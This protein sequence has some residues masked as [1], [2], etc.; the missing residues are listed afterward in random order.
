MRRCVARRIAAP[1]VQ[2]RGA[3]PPRR[4]LRAAQHR[5]RPRPHAPRC[6]RERWSLLRDPPRAHR[7]PRALS[8]NAGSARSSPRRRRAPASGAA[9][10]TQS[11]PHRR[12]PLR[13]RRRRQR[14]RASPL[15]PR[16]RRHATVAAAR[17]LRRAQ[18]PPCRRRRQRRRAQPPRSTRA[19]PRPT[20]G[21]GDRAP[22][23]PPCRAAPLPSLAPTAPSPPPLPA[24]RL[25]PRRRR[26]K[27]S[28]WRVP[29][30]AAPRQ[31]AHARR[32]LRSPTDP[33]FV[34]Q[35]NRRHTIQIQIASLKSTQPSW[36]ATRLAGSTPSAVGQPAGQPGGCTMT[37]RSPRRSVLAKASESL[38][39]N[40]ATLRAT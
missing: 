37:D 14:A 7:P 16:R 19:P 13:T 32:P 10:R 3:P 35:V 20:P 12:P 27:R 22:S 8:P 5:R 28:L 40:E 38:R 11:V 6:T 17:A 1:P 29:R 36:Q 9:G 26:G 18:L 30:R 31:C 24:H 4:G 21:G 39:P 15:Q 23:P 34:N 2:C 25:S 33:N